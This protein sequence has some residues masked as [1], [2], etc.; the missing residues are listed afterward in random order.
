VRFN[1]GAVVNFNPVVFNEFNGADKKA[2][3]SLL[4][5]ASANARST[6]IVPP[7]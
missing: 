1:R 5:S 7:L 6:T 2:G 3:T 4:I